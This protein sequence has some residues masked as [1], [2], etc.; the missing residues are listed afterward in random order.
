LAVVALDLS[1]SGWFTWFGF[2]LAIPT[3]IL[4]R[5]FRVRGAF[6]TA[7][8]AACVTTVWMLLGFFVFPP[9]GR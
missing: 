4:S 7:A 2:A 1:V 5:F 9:G 6:I 3:M 8:A